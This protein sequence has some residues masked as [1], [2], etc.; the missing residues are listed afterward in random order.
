MIDRPK[1]IS[2][3]RHKTSYSIII[4]LNTKIHHN[5]Q[6]ANGRIKIKTNVCTLC[7]PIH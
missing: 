7:F 6:F 1:R 5:H 4:P 3:I 2:C